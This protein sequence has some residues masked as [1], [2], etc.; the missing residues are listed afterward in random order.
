MQIRQSI[1]W[2]IVLLF[3]ALVVTP[4][5]AADKV[6][7]EKDIAYLGPDRSEKGDL[8]RPAVSA[9]GHRFPGVLI[10]HG[11]GWSGGDKGAGRE[12]N[13]GT[14]LALNDYVG[15]SINY[16]LSTKNHP[17]WPQNLYD[18]KT[19]V[20]WLRMNAQRLNLDPQ[21]IGVIGG[22]AGGHLAAMV[23]MTGPAAGLDPSDP[24]AEYSCRVQAAVDLYGP[25][26]LTFWPK[27]ERL[28][29]MPASRAEKPEL[30]RLASPTTYADKSNPPL[31]ILQ[32][33]AD[34]TVPVEQSK[35]LAEALKKAGA[36]HELIIVE[37]APHSFHLQPKQRDLRP[38]V[39]GFFDRYLKPSVASKA[40]GS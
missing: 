20:R 19:A 17:T 25:A 4:L 15:F 13:I 30:Y 3:L 38:V 34:K 24:Y 33:T 39:L 23:A 40:K 26:D 29:M 22:S 10:I 35:V 37:G 27:S 8:Y 7:I 1:S 32:G 18:C 11:G 21:H 6:N 9:K 31:L 5:P 16:V 12:I 28:S 2:G 14:N 36:E